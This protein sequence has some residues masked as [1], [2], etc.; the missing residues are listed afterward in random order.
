MCERTVGSPDWAK[1]DAALKAKKKTKIP[2]LRNFMS[3]S[4]LKRE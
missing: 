3:S 1:S 4:L 2:I